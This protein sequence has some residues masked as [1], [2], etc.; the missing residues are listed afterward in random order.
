MVNFLLQRSGLGRGP[1]LS[2]H[3]HHDVTDEDIWD[4]QA[5]VSGEHPQATDHWKPFRWRCCGA[6]GQRNTPHRC[7]ADSSGDTPDAHP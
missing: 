4:W 5:Q 7:E 3:D 1:A 6:K 2:I